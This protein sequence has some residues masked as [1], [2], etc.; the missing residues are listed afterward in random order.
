MSRLKDAD[1]FGNRMK[2]Y[3]AV[4]TARRLDPLRPIYARIDGRAF[5][6][7]TRGM[8]KPFDARLTSAM[9]A[10]AKHLVQHTH[11]RLGYV[12]SDEISLVW[13]AEGAGSDIFFSGKVQKM[14]SVLASLAAAKF[15]TV[16]P[17]A[18]AERLPHFDARVFPL[19]DRTEA[20][21]A[22]LW[23]AM[24]ARKNGISM[25]AQSLFSHKQLHGKDQKAMLAMIAEAGVDYDSFPETARFGVFLKREVELRELTPLELTDI[26]EAH[27]PTGPVERTVIKEIVYRAFHQVRDREAFVFGGEPQAVAA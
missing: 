25:I 27:R 11:A 10:T 4:E 6:R 17:P 16:C 15:A 13:Q 5:S 1:D 7:F 2:A 24:D 19:P 22:F 14:V 18:F 26:P 8:T 23:R 20:A 9:V 21:N 3:E 12:Q